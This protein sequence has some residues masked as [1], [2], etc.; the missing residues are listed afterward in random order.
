MIMKVVVANSKVESLEAK[1]SKL[2]K[3]LIETMDQVMKAKEKVKELKDVLKV[4]K[5]LVIQKDE[6][7]QAALLKTDEEHEKV[8]A[9][10]LEFDHFSN[11]QFVQ[12]F[13]GFELLCRWMMKHHSQVVDFANLYFKAIDTE[14]LADETKEKE[15]ETIVDAIEG[16]GTIV[17]GV[18]DEAHMDEGHI[19]EVANAP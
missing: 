11:L 9:K 15:D 3:D 18:V 2:R 12:Y 5:R 19:K 8:I 7:V 17:G 6:E 1:S 13:K 14:I 4:E 16:D 10:F